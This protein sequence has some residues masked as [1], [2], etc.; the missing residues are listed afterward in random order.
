MRKE[1][2]YPLI[3]EILPHQPVLLTDIPDIDL[4]V[5]Q[6]TGF[7]EKKL[8]GQKRH[9]KDK[10]LTKTMINNY[11]KAGILIP[12]RQK[13]YSRQHIETLLMLYN[14]KQI[15][16]INDISLLFSILQ[17]PANK[18]NEDQNSANPLIDL[19]YSL[20]QEINNDQAEQ[21]QEV[22]EEKIG[23]IQEKTKN[24]EGETGELIE[25]FLLAIY[26]VSQAAVQ[27]RMAEAI[28]DRYFKKDVPQ[29]GKSS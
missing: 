18:H 1:E 13:K 24:V 27:K 9:P 25:W 19:I 7:I 10:L 12:P 22:C 3:D 16:S 2:L 21:L 8:A 5:D 17:E 14:A 11:A 23:L 15:L 28:I 29:K 6:V 26:L 4:Y 20:V